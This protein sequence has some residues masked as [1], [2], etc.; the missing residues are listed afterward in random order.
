MEKLT[1]DSLRNRKTWIASSTHKGE[2]ELCFKTHKLLK[3][4]YPNILTI[5][6]P[7]HIDRIK[8]IMSRVKES[9]LKAQIIEND[10]LS[11]GDD[12]DILLINSFGSLGKYYEYCKNIFIGK[13]LNKELILEGGQNPI[14]AARLGCKIYHGPYVYNFVEVYEF[15]KKNSISEE[16]KSPEELSSKIIHDIDNK[17]KIDDS[18]IKK[19]DIFGK[20]IFDN[21]V[22]R[23]EELIRL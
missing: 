7:R 11:I 14:E 4:K 17:L 15:L 5:I 21:T 10:D 12:I 22:Q 16:I 19:I 23:L 8:T 6:A 13:S 1:I 2:E 9:D 3:N 18:K 20:N